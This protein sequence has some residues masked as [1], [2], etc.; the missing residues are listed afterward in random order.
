[1]RPEPRGPHGTLTDHETGPGIYF[2]RRCALNRPLGR[3]AA[4]QVLKHRDGVLEP[5]L[6][7][8][9]ERRPGW[10]WEPLSGSDSAALDAFRLFV[11]WEGHADVPDDHIEEDHKL[12]EWLWNVRRRKLIGTL[13]PMLEAMLLAAI[14]TNRVGERPFPWKKPETQWRLG[15]DAARQFVAR[16]GRIDDMAVDHVETIDGHP[17]QL[18]RWATRV[19]H[20][21]NTGKTTLTAE[22]IAA[23]EALPGWQW[24]MG[25]C[26]RRTVQVCEPIDIGDRPHGRRGFDAGCR[27]TTCVDEKRAYTRVH[28]AER[29]QA[30][31][32][33]WV[34][35]RDV[36]EHL[37]TLMASEARPLS[38]RTDRTIT[39]MA[40]AA[41][42]G[43]APG[44]V[45]ALISGK[46]SS[47]HP[48]H[49]LALLSVTVDDVAAARSVPRTRGRRGIAGHNESADPGPTWALVDE[50]IEHGWPI[51]AIAAGLGYL[52]TSLPF[53]RTRV[54]VTHAKLMR[55]FYDSL[56][57]DL[58]PPPI[59]K[60]PR[61]RANGAPVNLH[62]S[63]A[64]RRARALL[65]Q[66]YQPAQVARLTGLSEAI[67]A[68]L[69]ASRGADA[70]SAAPRTSKAHTVSTRRGI[71]VD[72]RDSDP[73]QWARALLDQG[74]QPAHIARRTGLSDAVVATILAEWEAIR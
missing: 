8:E 33:F 15:L 66:N 32:A 13:A 46:E 24:C 28:A 7:A 50:L 3:W 21:H 2:G 57:G 49:R 68:T 4:I 18:Y 60:A 22:Q 63:E 39:P 37:A 35:A 1:V 40:I 72:E 73:E 54:T 42:A 12:G 47:C 9:L 44:I 30:Y 71:R 51:K 59:L 19:R 16:G 52:K 67:V 29:R 14:P 64:E 45:R 20:W 74:Y 36:A 6:R 53:T 27:C 31:R 38:D 43:V 17:L 41:A 61:R 25:R 26:G 34:D 62:D 11:G 70:D 48:T 10:N 58:T 69:L 65:D 56:G 55:L 23:V 5:W